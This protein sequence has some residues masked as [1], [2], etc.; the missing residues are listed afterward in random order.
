MGR[1]RYEADGRTHALLNR[2]VLPRAI[3][4]VSTRSATGTDNLA[5]H[6]YFTVASESPPVVAFASI[7]YKDT[8]RNALDTQEF[9]VN[10]APAALAD[11]INATSTSFPPEVSEFDAVGLTRLPSVAVQAP[12]VSESSAAIE[13]VL[14]G[15]YRFE[16]S[17][18]L[19]GRVV[20]VTV[21]AEV[22]GERGPEAA[23]LRPIARLGGDQWSELGPIS[24]RRRP[25]YP[26][27]TQN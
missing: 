22:L 6:S 17:T 18:V 19:F 16:G 7:G 4:W 12:S 9:V 10:L 20:A 25:H 5:P 11:Q 1:R 21:A 3:A 13:C 8:L 2:L 14:H 23:L 26:P 15:T 27:D 24:S